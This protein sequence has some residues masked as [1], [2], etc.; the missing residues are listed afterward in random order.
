ME[1]IK[2]IEEIKEI[3]NINNPKSNVFDFIAKILN[4]LILELFGIYFLIQNF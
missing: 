3:P 2:E 1:K 4:I